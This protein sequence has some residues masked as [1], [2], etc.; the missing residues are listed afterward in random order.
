MNILIDKQHAT[1]MSVSNQRKFS[2]FFIMFLYTSNAYNE[3]RGKM[4]WCWDC[5]H[6]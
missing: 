6:Y 2:P 5:Y 4:E 3:L 1:V